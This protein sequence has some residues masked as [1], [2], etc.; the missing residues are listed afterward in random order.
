MNF[1]FELP[2]N[3][4]FA[5]GGI[6]QLHSHLSA[7]GN[8]ALIVGGNSLNTQGWRQVIEH[9]LELAEVQLSEVVLV[10]KDPTH[11]HVDR[12]ISV[13]RETSPSCII[14]IGG[15][16]VLDAGKAASVLHREQSSADWVGKNAPKN[17]AKIPLIAIPTTAGTGS[18]VTKGAIITDL[19]RQFKSGI[20]GASLYPDIALIDP[21]LIESMP[22]S[23]KNET[24]FDAFTHLLETLITRKSSPINRSLSLQGLSYL[25]RS[26]QHEG[27]PLSDS[28]LREAL[29]VAAL[30]GGINIGSAGSCLPH[31]MQQA[32]G[33][34]KTIDCS[35]G[36]GL[37]CVYRA[38][39]R[40]VYPYARAEIDLVL[41]LFAQDSLEN[42][43]GYVQTVL[44]LPTQLSE[45]GYQRDMIDLFCQSIS[46][47]IANDP[48]EPVSLELIREIYHDA[49]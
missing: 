34:V 28:N 37:S 42:L 39:S 25:A 2:S 47:D 44:D 38:W 26:F 41:E 29:S 7:F 4:H 21:N 14:A 23:V 45:I 48:I 3:I 20:R 35:H 32:M 40:R 46:G 13:V 18:E 12:I 22:D 10:P 1:T 30:L 6:N 16:S 43:I 49:F 17:Y 15:G 5:S 33:A 36:R 19:N 24:V 31:R 27:L 9:Q 8:K 11:E